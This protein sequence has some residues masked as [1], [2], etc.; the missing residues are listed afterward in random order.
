MIQT[1]GPWQRSVTYLSKHWDLVVSVWPSCLYAIIC[2]IREAEKLTVGQDLTLT[3][4]H[5]VKTLLRGANAPQHQHH[6]LSSDQS[7][8]TFAAV[9]NL[10]PATLMPADNSEVPFHDDE[11]ILDISQA[12]CPDLQDISRPEAEAD[13]YRWKKSPMGSGRLEQ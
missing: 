9:Q 6:S 8:L 11:D 10:H 1:L 12:S 5:A 13:L 4:L 3:V 2:Y 7:C